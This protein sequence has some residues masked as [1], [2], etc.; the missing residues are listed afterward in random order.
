MK[1]K[2]YPFPLVQIDWKDAQTDHGWEYEE[3]LK[4]E[5]PVVITV[6]F[7]VKENDEAVLIA[8]SVGT[9]RHSNRRVI[10]PKGMVIARKVLWS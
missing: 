5:V 8:S 9:D 1:G 3:D 2:K 10:I 4:I 7:L 6:G